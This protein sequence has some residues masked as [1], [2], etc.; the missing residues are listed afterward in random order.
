[1]E[2]SVSPG[3]KQTKPNGGS[4]I[5]SNEDYS[6]SSGA[7]ACH[8]LASISPMCGEH[9]MTDSHATTH[10]PRISHTQ[11]NLRPVV[12]LLRCIQICPPKKGRFRSNSA[13]PP[14]PPRSVSALQHF[15]TIP[16]LFGTL[17]VS[18]VAAWLLKRGLIQK[19]NKLSK[20]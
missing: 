3:L 9:V 18:T 7:E 6:C 15:I 10:P 14:P 1:M 19:G 12:F 4:G 2:S 8:L 16:Q 13:P 11:S 5:R 20:H 17:K